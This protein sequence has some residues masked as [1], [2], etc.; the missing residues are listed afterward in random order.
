MANN[1]NISEFVLNWNMRV[2]QIFENYL[3]NSSKNRLPTRNLFNTL[4]KKID[5][6]FNN[7]LIE[8]D[9]INIITG[10]RGVGKT[11][12]LLQLLN[13]ESYI[14]IKKSYIFD[15]VFIDVGRLVNEGYTL[16]DFFKYYE[17]EKGIIFENNKNKIIFALGK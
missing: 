3:F 5:D 4:V 2:P 9:K 11:T 12:L 15:K 16:N 8:L 14:D 7:G 13:F 6:F 10:I 1:N 17:E